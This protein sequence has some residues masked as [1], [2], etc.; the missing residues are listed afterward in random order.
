MAFTAGSLSSVAV[1]DVLA[2]LLASAASGGTTPYSYQ[3]YRSTTSGF[4]PGPLTAISGAT[5]LSL[6][7]AITPGT[8][9]YYKVLATDSAGT[10]SVVSYAQLQVVALQVQVSQN[11]FGQTVVLG[12]L[13]LPFNYNTISVRLESGSVVPGQLLKWSTTSS[14]MPLVVAATAASDVPAGVANYNIKNA[15]FSAGDVLEMS[16]EGNVIYL[17]AAAA[18]N[19]GQQ[20][21]SLPA[22]VAGG[23]N[24][25][26]IPVTGSSGLPI[27][28]VS[29]DTVAVGSL[30]RIQLGGFN[31]VD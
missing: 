15:S 10:P 18:I 8:T 7:N 26:V 19:R 1:T 21:T 16:R 22:A 29:L 17:V 4:S 6:S 12:Q 14:I 23:T 3:W 30:V 11:Q 28:G 5:A 25:G 31:D 27:V 20:V 13:Q 2:S 9:Y 24:G